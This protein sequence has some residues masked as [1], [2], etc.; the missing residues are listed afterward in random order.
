MNQ[1]K[2]TV[3]IKKRMLES[4]QLAYQKEILV[5]NKKKRK[6]KGI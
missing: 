6:G 3:L 2:E 4:A 5:Y 1:E